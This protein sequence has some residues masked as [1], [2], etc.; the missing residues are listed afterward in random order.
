M[1]VKVIKVTGMLTRLSRLYT[2]NIMC[3]CAT[4]YL[5]IMVLFC[6]F[7]YRFP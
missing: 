5:I 7:R 2:I 3:M 6:L 4:M 1:I